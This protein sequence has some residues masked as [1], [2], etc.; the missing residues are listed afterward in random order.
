MWDFSW[1][2]W[3][4]WRAWL[5]SCVLSTLPSSWWSLGSQ[6]H[7][8]AS[9][10]VQ[11]FFWTFTCVVFAHVSL[12]KQVT[13]PIPDSRVEKKCYI[14]IGKT[15][16]YCDLFFLSHLPCIFENG[17][18]LSSILIGNS[19]DME[20]WAIS[21]WPYNFESLFSGFCCLLV[22]KHSDSILVAGPL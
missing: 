12:F 1:K 19:L 15:T 18:S 11:P 7:E 20:F 6:W 2:G 21:I 9:P 14:L 8:R 17:L 3:D 13:W 5:H 22:T 10:S 16:N 4:G